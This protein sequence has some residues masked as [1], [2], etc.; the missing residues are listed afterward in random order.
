MLNF[1]NDFVCKI[2]N[3]SE[4]FC[5]LKMVLIITVTTSASL[6]TQTLSPCLTIQILNT[7]VYFID[8]WYTSLTSVHYNLEH[9]LAIVTDSF[10]L[11]NLDYTTSFVKVWTRSDISDGV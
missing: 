10:S 1:E 4:P 3:K 9:G 2:L 6:C 5:L 8:S 7:R 11:L